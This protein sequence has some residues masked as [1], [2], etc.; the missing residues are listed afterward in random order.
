MRG[1]PFSRR[2]RRAKT[3]LVPIGVAI[4]ATMTMAVTA[5]I[6]ATRGISP[7][8]FSVARAEEES[9][10]GVLRE[11]LGDLTRQIDDLRAALR[12]T[13]SQSRT[14]SQE[15]IRLDQEILRSELSLERSGRMI[16]SLGEEISGLEREIAASE[17][18]IAG[19]REVVA[20]LLRAIAVSDESFLLSTIFSGGTLADLTDQFEA[21]TRI[22]QG[23]LARITEL[24]ELEAEVGE[25]KLALEEQ[26]R[27]EETARQLLV[28]ARDD[29]LVKRE[30]RSRFLSETRGR[31]QDFANQ[32]EA[33]EANAARIRTQLY[34]LADIG[35]ALSF[36]E[37][38]AVAK[39]I[40][41]A[42]GVRPAFLLAV[43]QK[44][45]RL[46]A[47]S[48]TGF[49]RTDMH[50]RDWPAFLT[51]TQELG[52]DPDQAPVSRKPSYGWG[53][54]MGPAQFLPATWLAYRDRIIALTGHTPPSPWSV[55]D[56]FA[57]AA[58]K[59]AAGGANERTPAAEWRAAMIYF[60]GGNWKNPAYAFYGDAVED[61][62]AAFQAQI[63]ILEG[64]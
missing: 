41:D 8:V 21:A 1:I 46:G 20:V 39:P 4:F 62:S 56:A 47:L 6:P 64:R 29:L 55:P 14:I 18:E 23:L 57:A 38:F 11:Q 10:Q 51:I 63:N 26:R 9:P 43:L 5:T 40:S 34:L 36:G 37:A 24:R 54:A 2:K 50:P 60:A 15:R 12:E 16:Q 27:N 32:I 44:E 19:Q 13:R 59:L 28:V 7:P 53:G 48:G 61:L 30:L 49:W 52:L 35:K 33:T 45:S 3:R 42:V 22:E 58:I 25:R 17:A 31:E